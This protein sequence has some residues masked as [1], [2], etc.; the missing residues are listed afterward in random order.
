MG[1][2]CGA[3]PKPKLVRRYTES[4]VKGRAVCTRELKWGDQWGNQSVPWQ[5][6]LVF[7]IFWGGGHKFHLSVF[8]TR[9]EVSLSG[10]CTSKMKSKVVGCCTSK[11]KSKG[12]GWGWSD[13]QGEKDAREI[14]IGLAKFVGASYFLVCTNCFK[15]VLLCTQLY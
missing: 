3:C 5:A 14:L 4:E 1:C 6:S 13:K 7:T 12:V 8:T 10:C 11:V 2:Q 15:F 9:S